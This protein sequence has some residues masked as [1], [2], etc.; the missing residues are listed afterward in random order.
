MLGPDVTLFSPH[1][2]GFE[3]QY[4]PRKA[5]M[6]GSEKFWMAND[7]EFLEV[8]VCLDKGNVLSIRVRQGIRVGKGVTFLS[9][10]SYVFIIIIPIWSYCAYVR[11]CSVVQFSTKNILF[12]FR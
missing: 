1:W 4:Q 11:Y 12:Y 6:D 9:F 8:S 7:K 10:T 3:D 5:K 2:F